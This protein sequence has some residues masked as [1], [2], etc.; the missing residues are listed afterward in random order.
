MVDE[1]KVVDNRSQELKDAQKLLDESLTI[2]KLKN[3]LANN[4][5]E[6]QYEENSYRVRK[7]T[8][9]E[10]QKVYQLR[11]DKQIELLKEKNQDGSFKNLTE[12][13]LKVLYK[14]RGIDIEKISKEIIRLSK[15]EQELLDVL[16]KEIVEGKSNPNL[17]QGKKEIEEIRI[18]AG[19][20]IQEKAN[21][22]EVAIE[23]QLLLFI[24]RYFTFLVTQIKDD[25]TT[26][27]GWNQVWSTIEDYNEERDDQLV[28]LANSYLSLL[29]TD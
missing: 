10:K 2:E 22:L 27:I 7:P 6:F 13:D 12:R 14:E 24:Y 28:T 18:E 11:C 23:N 16:G 29:L 4:V 20:L 9:Q 15:K 17:E 25:V 8:P 5:I 19:M 1:N 3:A 26:E 21:L